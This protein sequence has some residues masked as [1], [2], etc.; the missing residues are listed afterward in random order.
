[1]PSHRS[2]ELDRPTADPGARRGADPARRGRP[3]GP[4]AGRRGDL[5]VGTIPRGCGHLHRASSGMSSAA[6]LNLAV[7]PT[8][9][10]PSSQC[11]EARLL[12]S[13]RTP[14]CH[15]RWGGQA[16][17]WSQISTITAAQGHRATPRP[18]HPQCL[19]GGYG[20]RCSILPRHGGNQATCLQNRLRPGRRSRRSPAGRPVD[21]R[22]SLHCRL[23]VLCDQQHPG[24]RR[25]LRCGVRR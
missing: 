1:M 19:Q 14:R 6:P 7:P 18:R 16:R 24:G 11:G 25:R 4:A 20:T 2:P 8:R 10:P 17:G 9:C 5:L 22:R 13:R 12:P 23:L 15:L 21:R 3:V